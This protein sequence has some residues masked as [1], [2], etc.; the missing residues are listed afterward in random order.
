MKY[1]WAHAYFFAKKYNK[2]YITLDNCYILLYTVYKEVVI[3]DIILNNNSMVPIYEQV[4]EQIK[5]N[6][7]SG[8][9]KAD[10]VLPSVRTLSND[11]KISALT[12]K[13][14]YDYLE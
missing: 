3:L 7:I 10:D 12:V 6:I 13:K 5:K 9:L 8:K 14:A 2:Q 11:L 1:A 4:A